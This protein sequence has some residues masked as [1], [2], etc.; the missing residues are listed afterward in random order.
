MQMKPSLS[1]RVLLGSS[2]FWRAS[3]RLLPPHQASELIILNPWW[4][5]LI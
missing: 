2:P 5:Q 1:W 4:F 3:C